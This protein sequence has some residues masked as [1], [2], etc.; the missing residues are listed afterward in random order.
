M[1][2]NMTAKL[3]LSK[4]KYE[5]ATKARMDLDWLPI[6]VQ[7]EFKSLLVYKSLNGHGPIYLSHLP[8]EMNKKRLWSELHKTKLIVPL[9]NNTFAVISLIVMGP[10]LWNNLPDTVHRKLYCWGLQKLTK[11]FI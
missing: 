6:K 7:T 9:L 4:D 5:S 1:V 2:Q 11:N 10:R 8:S 3:V